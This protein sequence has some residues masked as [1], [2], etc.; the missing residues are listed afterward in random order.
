MWKRAWILVAAATLQGASDSPDIE[1]VR[2][3]AVHY[4]KTLPNYTCTQRVIRTTTKYP[5]VA[6]F[7]RPQQDAIEEQVSYVDGREIHKVLK[8]NGQPPGSGASADQGM[9][10]RGEWA[11]LLSTMFQPETQTEF[12]FEKTMPLNG[13][14][15]DVFSFRVPQERGYVLAGR[16]GKMVVGYR[17]KL[18]AD[19][20]TAAVVHIEMNCTGI[21]PNPDYSEVGLTLDYKSTLVAGRRFILPAHYSLHARNSLAVTEIETDYRDYRRFA[22]DSTVRFS[23]E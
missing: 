6:N 4:T 3:Y 1:K 10:S 18:Y 8:M 20:A 17:G 7:R 2:D 21:R 12:R 22:A 11:A 14:R 19:A 9:V 5:V 16:E 15:V 23:E 13:A